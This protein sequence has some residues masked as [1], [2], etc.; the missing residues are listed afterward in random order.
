[1]HPLIRTARLTG[2]LYLS[3]AVTGLLGFLVIR[4]R[5]FV[6][7]DAE[8]TV[9]RL[10][11]NELLARAGVALELL[12]VVAQALT[13]V[14]FF[15]L[16][17]SV[18]PVAAGSITAFGLANAVAILGSAA[19]LATAA[20]LA[21]IPVLRGGLAS[22]IA[23]YRAANGAFSSL[24]AL[25]QVDGV[26]P[27][28]YA[29]A[30]PYLRIGARLGGAAVGG[31]ATP[32][33]DLTATLGGVGTAGLLGALQGLLGGVLLRRGAL[34]R[35]RLGAA[36][37]LQRVQGR[38]AAALGN[39]LVGAAA[40]EHEGGGA[41]QRGGVLRRRDPLRGHDR[42]RHVDPR[43]PGSSRVGVDLGGRRSPRGHRGH[44]D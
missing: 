5:L 7:G 12:I 34:P 31:V 3:L 27:D 37:H 23:R 6:P 4:P 30:R 28:V 41:E 22:A 38:V 40:G 35:D 20:E 9:A 14:W 13:A 43:W 39:V 16:F 15:R 26:T 1:M 19:L 24:P 18:D 42:L 33:G 29:Q 44:Q 21:G 17:Q 8:T 32:L 36:L 25:Q 2:L 10:V 11:E